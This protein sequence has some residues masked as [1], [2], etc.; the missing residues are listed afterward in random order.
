M[1]LAQNAP[2]KRQLQ[3]QKLS[4]GVDVVK[5]RSQTSYGS[6]ALPWAETCSYTFCSVL[7]K[8]VNPFR[9]VG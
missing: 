3:L 2:L 1:L 9:P 6:A 5:V 4:T 7:L 8:E